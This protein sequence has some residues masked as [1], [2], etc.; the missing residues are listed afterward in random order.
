VSDVNSQFENC[1]FQP[2]SQVAAQNP[3]FCRDPK[4]G[5]H[6]FNL[7]QH[8]ASIIMQKNANDARDTG[9]PVVSHID[10]WLFFVGGGHASHENWLK[11][12]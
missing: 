5:E 12:V 4:G 8:V 7:I 6:A 1:P 9:G 10:M 11:S 3:N 2:L